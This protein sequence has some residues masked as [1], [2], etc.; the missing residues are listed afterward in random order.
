MTKESKVHPYIDLV[1]NRLGEI[2]ATLSAF[3][4]MHNAFKQAMK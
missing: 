3:E 1:K 4:D 2:D